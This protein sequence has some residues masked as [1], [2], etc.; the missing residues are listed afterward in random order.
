MGIYKIT[1]L[2]TGQTYIG[3][4]KDI[5]NRYKEH[6]YHRDSYID[7]VIDETGDEYFACELLEEC[8]EEDL[9]AREDYYIRQ[10]H[11]NENGFGYNIIRGG[12]HNKSGELNNNVK[13]TEQDV[14]DIR[15]AYNNH[16]RKYSVYEK[17]KN[18]VTES[19]FSNIWAGISW[20]NIH[21]DVYTIENL[22]YY[23]KGTSLGENGAKA[24]F[25][26]QE[27][28]EL[29]KRYVNESAKSIYES[30]K[31]KCGFQTL[32]QILWGRHYSHLPIYDKRNKIWI[33]N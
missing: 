12:Q 7:Q 32:Q 2:L 6:L 26:D 9:D 22:N 25:T 3:Q 24:V 31:E 29:R 8:K 1:N 28:I 14:Y 30:V 10:Y 4:S 20:P 23:K 33:N 18:K 16:E 15:E 19:Y 5:S 21:Y 17:Y 13:L 11:S 27:V